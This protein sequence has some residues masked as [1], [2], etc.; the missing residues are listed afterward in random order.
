MEFARLLAGFKTAGTV[1]SIRSTGRTLHIRRYAG[2]MP[3]RKFSADRTIC[4][5]FTA[6]CQR[7]A[8]SKTNAH[9][10]GQN[11][12][13]GFLKKSGAYVNLMIHTTV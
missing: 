1:W 13:E 10:Y 12:A 6:A 2:N 11:D 5:A 8:E 3:M 7:P 9:E 4:T